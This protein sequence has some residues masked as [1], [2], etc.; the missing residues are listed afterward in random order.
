MQ[1][2]QISTLLNEVSKEILGSD[3]IFAEDLSDVVDVGQT[4]LNVVADNKAFDS[5]LGAIINKTGKTVTVDRSY[6][7]ST[8]NITRDAWEWGSIMEKIRIALPEASENNTWG[9]ER[10]KKY[11]DILVYDPPE[12]SASFYNKRVTFDIKM[13]F[14]A[15]YTLRESFKSESALNRFFSAIENRIRTGMTFYTANMSQRCVNNL[16]VMCRDRRINLLEMYNTENSKALTVSEAI[17]DRDF[18]RF[19]SM[20]IKLYSDY[21][22]RLSHLFNNGDY[23]THSP[24]EYQHFCVLSQFSEGISTYALSDTFHNE[25]VK[26]IKYETVPYW[27]GVGTTKAGNKLAD[28]YDFSAVSQIKLIPAD[29]DTAVTLNGVVGILFDRDAAAVCCENERVTS[30]YNADNETTKY[31]YKWDCGYQNDLYEN[32]IVFTIEDSAIAK[33]TVAAESGSATLFGHQ[34]SSFQTGV[35]V[36]DNKITGTLTFIEGGLAQSGPLSGD[37]HFLA[38]KFTDNANADKIEVGLVP[39]LGTGLV[40]LDSDMNA[41]FKVTGTLDGREQVLKVITT[42]GTESRTQTYDLS[43]LTLAPQA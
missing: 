28:A 6:T 20:K 27:Q 24:K 22:I 4:F 32:C 15:E 31:Y 16:A 8:P 25:F 34:V 2:K 9:L 14:P 19:C 43:G 3:V 41:V 36:N 39:S 35:T 18:L 13:S 23:D 26:L 42:K 37:G 5:V 33:T 30:F 7:Q 17:T 10:G 1:R 21:M 12:V 38:L 11:D 29:G 40:A